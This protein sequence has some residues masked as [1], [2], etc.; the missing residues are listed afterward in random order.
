MGEN[1]K[2]KAG[3]WYCLVIDVDNGCSLLDQSSDAMPSSPVLET[4]AGD[5]NFYIFRLD[6]TIRTKAIT[7]TTTTTTTKRGVICISIR[8]GQT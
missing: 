8:L 3:P 2:Q 7:T 5:F 1:G 4:I 6:S